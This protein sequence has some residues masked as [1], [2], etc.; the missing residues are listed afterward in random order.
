[1]GLLISATTM[2][3]VVLTKDNHVLLSGPVNDQSVAQTAQ[4]LGELS[5]KSSAGSVIYLV[6]DTPG[7]SVMAGSQLADF[8]KALPQK[9]K[10]ICIFCASTGYILFQSFD[11]RLVQPSSTLM[12]HR[13]S[14]SGAGGQIPGEL[15]TRINQLM[16]YL[17]EIDTKMAK[18]VGI[19]RQE[20]QALIYNELWLSGTEAV[21]T[22]HADKL[23]KIRCDKDLLTGYFIVT[24]KQ[25]GRAHV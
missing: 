5:V 17:S 1:M 10:P 14:L 18:R 24:G 7:G 11:E 9:I 25:I 19:S 4:K 21:K 8:A 6:L 23:E 20:Y 12:S 13:A 3:D 2:A 22:K 15:I 16:S